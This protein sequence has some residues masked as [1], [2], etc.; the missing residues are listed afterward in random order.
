VRCCDKALEINP[1]EAEAWCSKGFALY[2]LERYEEAIICLD[3]AL[4]INPKLATAKTVKEFVE[5]KL[6]ELKEE[7]ERKTANEW[8]DKG[9]EFD[10]LGEYEEAIR[11]YASSKTSLGRGGPYGAV[12]IASGFSHYY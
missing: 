3:K 8:F 5:E 2:K 12:D 4:E 1:K 7:I 11:Y 10:V 6:R 9:I